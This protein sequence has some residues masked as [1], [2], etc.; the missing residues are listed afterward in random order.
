M[1]TL[2]SSSP[3]RDHSGFGC[4][5]IG[6][7]RPARTADSNRRTRAKRPTFAAAVFIVASLW[8]G[9]FAQGASA[10]STCGDD[11]CVDVV[12][13]DGIIDDIVA[14]FISSSIDRA[15]DA[16]DVVAV[17]LQMDS[18]GAAVSNERLNELA[19]T[20]HDSAVPV[21]VWIGASGARAYGASAELVLA[22]DSSGIAPGA[23]IGDVGEFR[24]DPALL[25]SGANPELGGRIFKGE[26][27]VDA[28]IIDRFD[29]TL[30]D[31]I[32]NL[33]AV[34]S[35]VVT[36]DGK[37]QRQPV[38]RVRLSKLPLPVQIMHT[39]ASPAVAYLLL[40]I[41]AALLLFE[42]F[43]AGVGVAGVVGAGFVLLGGYGL[44]ELPHRNWA[45]ALFIASFVA[46]AI[47][48]QTGL[49]RLWTWIGFVAFT[50]SS[51]FLLSDFRPTW[52][53][54][55]CGIGGIAAVV[56]TGMP[57]M[58][59]A[60]FGTPYIGREWLEGE[61]GEVTTE[62]SPVGTVR[63]HDVDW[64]ARAAEGFS[65]RVGSKV[66]VVGSD[67]LTIEVDAEGSSPES[68]TER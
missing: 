48:M 31:H 57:S 61:T 45:L 2:P 53:A 5:D 68:T 3:H 50:V 7:T 16:G 23:R 12:S 66:T 26:A 28:G 43:T 46:F 35:K 29:P 49:A 63:I 40:V 1:G 37:E 15:N 65:A 39:A 67:R 19:H 25:G 62:L 64:T 6:M 41:G 33:E 30:V 27:A 52:L 22:A 14:D 9:L 36:V 32:G 60:R 11:G 21:S 51:L 18:S 38:Q 58:N 47:D 4:D 59:R 13:V 42:F 44:G 56:F 10:R 24:L 54:L 8:M 34:D 20:I 55:I 17:V